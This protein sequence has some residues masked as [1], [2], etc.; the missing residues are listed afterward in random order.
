M[1]KLNEIENALKK[2]DANDGK[3]TKTARE[4]NIDL[5]TLRSWRD[6]RRE[7]IPLLKR[8]KTKT[9]SGLQKRKRK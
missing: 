1:N 4:L 6:K 8:G 7:N 3:L 9:T 5:Y 2:L